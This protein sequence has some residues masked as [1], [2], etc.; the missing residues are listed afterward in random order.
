MYILHYVNY[1]SIKTGYLRLKTKK[2]H[3]RLVNNCATSCDWS[4]KKTGFSQ[5]E[6]YLSCYYLIN[7]VDFKHSPLFGPG[8]F[9]P[10]PHLNFSPW[11]AML[12]VWLSHPRKGTSLTTINCLETFFGS[13][14][15]LDFG[16]LCLLQ[17]MYQ[18]ASSPW[19]KSPPHCLLH[20]QP[21]NGCHLNS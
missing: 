20:G 21:L 17:H 14:K 12:T 9:F 2:G 11:A 10:F 8:D 4:R 5:L 15:I 16:L 18:L 6:S 7:T 1:I 19:A 13:L 3:K